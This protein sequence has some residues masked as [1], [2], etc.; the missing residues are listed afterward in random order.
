MA[1]AQSASPG[2]TVDFTIRFDN[3]GDQPLG[4]IVLVDNLTTRLEYVA[5][6]AQSS[7]PAK[8]SSQ[9][10]SG[11]SLVLRWEITNPV[12]PN[13]GGLVRFRCKVR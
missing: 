13:Q 4:N 2:E 10:N 1:S 5:D 3:I 12:E 9:A 7:V 11:E 6:S 8:F